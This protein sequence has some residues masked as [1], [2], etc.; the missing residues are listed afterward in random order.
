MPERVVLRERQCRDEPPEAKCSVKNGESSRCI[1]HTTEHNHSH[2]ASLL[3]LRA[4]RQG[5]FPRRT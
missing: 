1:G 5:S 3:S 4:N 2:D